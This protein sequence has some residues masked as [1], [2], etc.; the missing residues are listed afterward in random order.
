MC[1]Q[2]SGNRPGGST[3]ACV[4]STFEV[5][6]IFCDVL[7]DF[8]LTRSISVSFLDP[9]F[10]F[11]DVDAL[12]TVDGSHFRVTVVEPKEADAGDLDRKKSDVFPGESAATPRDAGRPIC[13]LPSETDSGE[14]ATEL[15]GIEY[16]LTWLFAG[17]CD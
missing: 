4:F 1:G 10:V 15:V 9:Q 8:Y 2:I 16:V 12:V 3:V 5:T 13:G 6:G 7:C 11:S 17:Q 14:Q